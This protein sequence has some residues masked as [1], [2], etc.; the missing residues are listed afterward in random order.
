MTETVTPYAHGQ[1]LTFTTAAETHT[2]TRVNNYRT[3]YH[4]LISENGEFVF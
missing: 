4:T 3:Y 2:H 1:R